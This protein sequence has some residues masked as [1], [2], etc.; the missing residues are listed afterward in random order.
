MYM[1]CC[2]DNVCNQQYTKKRFK[3]SCILIVAIEPGAIIAEICMKDTGTCKGAGGSMHIFDKDKDFQGGWVLVAE[4]LPY[5]AKEAKS[6]L[7]DPYLGLSD[8][9]N[10]EKKEISSL[11]TIIG[12]L[13]YS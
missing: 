8:N 2:F 3:G 11:R 6:I 9:E 10:H 12:F 7:I 4:Q 5:S 13:L 1:S